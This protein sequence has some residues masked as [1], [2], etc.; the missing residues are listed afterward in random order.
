MKPESSYRRTLR[1]R[2]TNPYLRTGLARPKKLSWWENLTPWKEEEGETFGNIWEKPFQA[3]GAAVTS[4]FTP[5]VKGTEDL[6]WWEREQAEYEQWKEPTW[7][8]P[9]GWK[10]RPTKGIVESLPWFAGT[11]TLGIAGKLGAAA[12]K[13]SRA[14]SIA[15]KAISPLT[16]AAQAEQAVSGAV[17]KGA[18]AVVKPLAKGAIK[19]AKGAVQPLT[20]VFGKAVKDIGLLERM[21]PF[22]RVF[23]KIGL[24]N[25]VYEPAFKASVKESEENMLINK[26]TSSLAKKISKDR[27]G[28]VFDAIENPKLLGKLSVEEKTAVKEINKFFDD[29]ATRLKLPKEIKR[30]NYINHIIEK[31]ARSQDGLS[32]GAIA[33]LDFKSPKKINMPFFKKRYGFKVGLKKDPV[34]AVSAYQRAAAKKFYREP[35]LKSIT[36]AKKKL[37]DLPNAYKYVDDFGKMLSEKPLS[38]DRQFDATLKNVAD[39]LGKVVIKL[40]GKERAAT[41]VLIKNLSSYGAS[42]RLAYNMAG[43]YY[44]VWLGGRPSS[45]LKNL[46]QNFLTMNEVG[47]RSFAGGLKLRGTKLGKQVLKE[48]EVIRSRAISYLPEQ[49]IGFSSKIVGKVRDAAMIMFRKADKINVQNATLAGYAE[50]I[51]KGLPHEWAMKRATEVAMKTQYLY[52]KLGSNF[53][54][55]SSLGRAITPFTSWPINFMELANQWVRGK[56]SRVFADY[57]KQTGKQIATGE[58]RTMFNRQAMAYLGLAAGAIGVQQ[59]TGFKAPLYTGQTSI[60]SMANMV[61]GDIPGM[62]IPGAVAGLIGGAI[63]GDT[64]Q[65]KTSLNEIDPSRFVLIAKQFKDIASGDREWADLF[66]YREK[67][68]APVPIKTA[69][70]LQR[71]LRMEVYEQ[72]EDKI[73]AQYPPNY[74]EI[75]TKSRTLDKYA[76]KRLLMQYPRIVMAMKQI[77]S[78]KKIWRLRNERRTFQSS[79]MF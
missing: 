74:S 25:D 67:P 13:G 4:P 39:D 29:W 3:F 75:A 27:K 12:A 54:A 1:N 32:A 21:R 66:V 7:N 76:A 60:A 68:K 48:S 36:T 18:G 77:E 24:Y 30:T 10:V 45:A 78:E 53:V 19:G 56:G 26:W 61:K 5:S 51:S 49:D 72:I 20:D 58:S 47:A 40:T 41:D 14:A 33:F 31:E 69:E 65:I 9:W 11:A 17:M 63:S 71:E 35:L 43:L 23:E 46:S 34:L 42:N 59:E 28:I 37:K 16:K 2:Y 44:S 79:G 8:T 57:V 55:Q 70:Q 50:G 15:G 22:H 52:T 6:P 73:W 38:I 62:T 64:R